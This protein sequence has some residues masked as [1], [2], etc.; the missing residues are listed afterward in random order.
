MRPE[1]SPEQRK[2]HAKGMCAVPGC[3]E[4]PGINPATGKPFWMCW[5]H[6][7]PVQAEPVWQEPVVLPAEKA[8]S[9][10]QPMRN[11]AKQREA[12]RRRVKR[13]K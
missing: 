12:F 8:P 3:E 13:Q 11:R 7:N 2:R 5:G 1:P 10:S 6:A 9:R 4:R